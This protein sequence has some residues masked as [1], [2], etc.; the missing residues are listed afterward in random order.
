MARPMQVGILPIRGFAALSCPGLTGRILR[1]KRA[2]RFALAEE[3]RRGTVEVHVGASRQKTGTGLAFLTG[4][5]QRPC[6][7]FRL[8]REGLRG[9]ATGQRFFTP[10]A[11]LVP[12]SI[13]RQP[14]SLVHLSGHVTL[15]RYTATSRDL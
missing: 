15:S 13:G 7:T 11:P 2:G 12:T 3:R 6:H 10:H 8:W 9:L 5:L 14:L 1:R 4:A